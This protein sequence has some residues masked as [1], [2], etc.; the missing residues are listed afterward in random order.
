MF[1]DHKGSELG[2][3]SV[4][5]RGEI[6]FKINHKRVSLIIIILKYINANSTNMLV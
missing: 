5:R 6:G 1:L 2:L 3:E 4:A